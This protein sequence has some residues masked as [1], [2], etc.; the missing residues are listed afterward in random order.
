MSVLF[1]SLLGSFALSGLLAIAWVG[2]MDRND[3]LRR[4]RRDTPVVL[5][6][7]PMA[8]VAIPAAHRRSRR[9]TAR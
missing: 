1:C 3:A 8:R 9:S 5:S 4:S 2:A 7:L 6:P